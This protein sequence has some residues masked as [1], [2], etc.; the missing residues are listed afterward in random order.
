M[1][2]RYLKPAFWYPLEKFMNTNILNSDNETRIA[3]ATSTY[4]SEKQ[5]YELTI[6][7]P[8][9]PKDAIEVSTIN[10]ELIIGTKKD[11]KTNIPQFYRKFYFDTNIDAST[12]KASYSNGLLV[13]E[14]KPEIPA[15]VSIK[16]D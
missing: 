5:I 3:R 14:V 8:G 13:I 16:I 2:F 9:V 1:T 15:K 6:E 10:N 11:D 12:I 4:N 7:L